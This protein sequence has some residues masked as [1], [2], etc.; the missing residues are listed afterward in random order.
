MWHSIKGLQDKGDF[1]GEGIADSLIIRKEDSEGTIYC[2][3]VLI[4]TRFFSREVADES[5][6][7]DNIPIKSTYQ[8]ECHRCHRST[9]E[10][11]QAILLL[12]E[13]TLACSLYDIKSFIMLSSN[14]EQYEKV[15]KKVDAKLIVV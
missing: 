1:T 6:I 2:M 11:L 10:Y 12:N 5:S 15:D 3:T 9:I 13:S 8:L 14:Y 4:L 7:S